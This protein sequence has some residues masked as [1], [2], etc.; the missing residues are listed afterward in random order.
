MI[1]MIFGCKAEAHEWYTGKTNPVTGLDCC[2]IDDCRPVDNDE[3]VFE[4]KDGVRGYRWLNA[5]KYEN[6]WIP[7]NQVLI[8]HDD[9]PHVCWWNFQFRC[10]MLPSSV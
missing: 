4:V 6:G 5:P 1:L 7:E 2:D 8:S 3:I 10:L 9:K